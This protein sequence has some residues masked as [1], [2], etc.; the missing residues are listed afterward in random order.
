MLAV[1][2]VQIGVILLV[3][4]W[5]QRWLQNPRPWAWGIVMNQMIMSVY[6]WHMTAM[7]AVIG[8]AMWLG[9]VGLGVEPGTGAW[10]SAR[11]VWLLVFAAQPGPWQAVPGAIVTCGGLIMMALT[12]V[13]AGSALGINWIAI[14]MVLAG[15]L[16]ATIR[17][18]RGKTQD[19]T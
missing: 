10:W 4:D 15:V 2:C 12:G 17:F 3:S 6:L 11:P 16:L 1:G 5:A 18:G 13:G 19:A 14:A 7:I 9:G 8:L